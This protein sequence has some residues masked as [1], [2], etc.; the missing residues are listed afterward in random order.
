V[1]C[2]GALTV[3]SG[4]TGN[5]VTTIKVGGDIHSHYIHSQR[6]YCRGS[7][8]VS[9]E[10]RNAEIFCND[11]VVVA[12]NNGVI[13]GGCITA[14][15]RVSVA[16]IGSVE[17]IPTEVV[18]GV[19][20]RYQS[21]LL[22]KQEEKEAAERRLGEIREKASAIIQSSGLGKDDPRF[23]RFGG[24]WKILQ[25]KVDSLVKE[26]EQLERLVYSAQDPAI[27]V[28]QMVYPGTTLRIKSAL[29]QVHQEIS[30]AIFKLENGEICRY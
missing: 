6:I 10:L 19:D 25:N 21:A 22:K 30:R 8:Y 20:S 15:N 11:E 3:R 16:Q 4:I 12:K 5:G 1:E 7:V 13:I 26:I 29:F 9:N 27:C 17:G 24:E 18:V 28:T 2:A 14:P 23:R